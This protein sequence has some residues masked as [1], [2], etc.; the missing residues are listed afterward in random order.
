MYSQLPEGT[1][2]SMSPLKLPKH[3]TKKGAT[4]RVSTV[5]I[6]VNTWPIGHV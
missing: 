5:A 6:P 4:G 3:T 2:T 1:R